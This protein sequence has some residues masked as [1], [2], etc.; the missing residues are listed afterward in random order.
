MFKLKFCIFRQ[1]RIGIYE[2]DDLKTL[3]KNFCRTFNLNKT[4]QISLINH[5][6]ESYEKYLEEQ[7]TKSNGNLPSDLGYS[8]VLTSGDQSQDGDDLRRSPG[9]DLLPETLGSVG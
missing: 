4:M 7:Q 5:L 3:A 1:G 8:C 2:G 6:E 9:Q